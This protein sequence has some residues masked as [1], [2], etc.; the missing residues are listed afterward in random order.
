MSFLALSILA[1]ALVGPHFSE[2]QP[3]SRFIDVDVFD[4]GMAV[5]TLFT[6]PGTA[7]VCTK[8]VCLVA[9]CGIR[10]LPNLP[11]HNMTT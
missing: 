5:T 7:Y 6:A 2:G 3:I 4:E 8:S 11:V 9:L 10:S 1:V